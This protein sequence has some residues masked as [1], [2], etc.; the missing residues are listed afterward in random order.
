[1]KIVAVVAAYDEEKT[2]G[3]L[4]R[5]L[6]ATFQGMEGLDSELLFVVEGRDE[7]RSILEE[8]SRESPGIR[9]LYNPEPSG[10]G[11]AF[12]RGFDAVPADADYVLTLDADLNHQPEEVPRLLQRLRESGADIL[13]GSRFLDA[14]EVEGSPL[15]KRMLSGSVNLLMRFLYGVSVHDK[16]SGFRLY[17][18][19][20]LREIEFRRSGFAFLPEILIRAHQMGLEVVEE[21]I[22]FI[23]R[24]EGKSKM[25]FWRTSLSYLALLGARFDLRP[26]R[27]GRR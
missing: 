7:T 12:R 26:S 21:P 13:V 24:R 5:R 15:W 17:R 1:M 14:S 2:I 22:H 11:A 23:F 6:L 8:I 19:E 4:T 18:A 27:R 10:L 9:I 16:T 20:A 25:A 3:T